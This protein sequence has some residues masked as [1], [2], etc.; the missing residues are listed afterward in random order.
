MLTVKSSKM[1]KLT[2]AM[3][4]R[5]IFIVVKVIQRGDL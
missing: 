1:F 5:H 2:I 4:I 3:Y